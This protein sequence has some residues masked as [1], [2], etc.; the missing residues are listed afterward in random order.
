[1]EIKS[2]DCPKCGA[3]IQ[4]PE[5]VGA[6]YRCPYCQNMIAL[7]PELREKAVT[8]EPSKELPDLPQFSRFVELKQLVQS[9]RKIDAIKLVRELTGLGLKEAK[10]L[11][12]QMERGEPVVLTSQS[13]AVQSVKVDGNMADLER[14]VRELTSQG[15]KIAAIKLLREATDLGLKEAKDAVEGMERGAPLKQ[16]LAEASFSADQQAAASQVEQRLNRNARIE[17]AQNQARP[18]RTAVGSGISC[19]GCMTVLFILLFAVVLPLGIWVMTTDNPV[20]DFIQKLN[21]YATASPITRFGEE[22]TGQGFFDD[23]RAIAVDTQGYVYVADYGSGR[24]QRFDASGKFQNL[25]IIPPPPNSNDVYITSMATDTNNRVYAT[26]GGKILVFDGASGE[27][28]KEISILEPGESSDVYVDN[29]Y[30]T[31]DNRIVAVYGGENILVTD[32]DG[33]VLQSI[34]DAMSSVT[35][36]SELSGETAVDGTGN[37]F[38]IGSFNAAV[39]KYAPDGTF[40]NKFSGEGEEPGQ[41][42]SAMAIE[43]D[44]YGRIFVSDINGINIF[45]NDGRLIARFQIGGVAYGMAFDQQGDLWVTTN[46][47]QVVEYRIKK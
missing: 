1:M 5:S 4:L 44:P 37:I 12:E 19:V 35:K 23:P 9:G 46:R 6:T 34:A 32:L 38:M 40:T 10:D 7:S 24:I 45:D 26:T 2:L 33:K 39:V 27:Q 16:A 18:I 36:D 14:K 29:I 42:S 3:P 28:T 22:G 8:P 31:N 20:N 11:V 15:N 41:I 21:P 43:V 25:W 13:V 17:A 47:T 30:I